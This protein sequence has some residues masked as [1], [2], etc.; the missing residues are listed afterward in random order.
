[1]FAKT[2]LI[3][4]LLLALAAVAQPRPAS[5]QTYPSGD[6]VIRAIWEQG[7]G[8]A[9]EIQDIAQILMD[10]IGPRLYGSPGEAA[11]RD[12]LVKMYGMWGVPTRLHEYG[13]WSGWQ[14]GYSHIDLV[15]PRVRTLDGMML[16]WSPGTNGPVE[17]DVLAMPLFTNGADF[18]AWL[19]RVE[20]KF[21]AYS[22]AEPTCRAPESWEALATPESWERMR[23]LQA[24]V[25]GAWMRSVRAAGGG[26]NVVRALEEAGAVGLLQGNWSAG[27]GANKI[28]SAPT[29]GIPALHLSCEDYGLVHRLASKGQ[30]ARIRLDARSEFLGELPVA[31]VLGEL[32]GTELPNEFVLL[33]A[34]LDS[35]DGASGATDNGSGTV[36]MM[37]A[38]RILKEVYPNPRRTIVVAHWGGEERGLIG[39]GAYAADHPEVVDGLQ[40]A[41]NQDN[42][43]WRIDFIRMQGFLGAG[44]RF[45]RWLSRIPPEI[46]RHIELDIPG[47]PERG[48]SDHMSFIC[49]EAAGFR[50]QSNYPDYRQYTWHTDIDTYDKLVFD[51]LRNNATLVAM[52][53]YLASEDPERMVVEPRELP[54]GQTWPGCGT[55]RRTSGG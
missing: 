53:A 22:H 50:L 39:S 3:T 10:S 31:N 15:A 4:T 44:E 30:G 40:A 1:M 13:T 17:A 24:Q 12:W 32:R 7:M 46:T 29:N 54:A 8:E 2:R 27:W 18:L 38:M 14:R 47:E 48:G 11:A 42:G 52:L 51:D 23:E 33:T 37:E 45:G 28:F 36:M 9:S 21:V 25:S 41:F 19:P 5:S 6:P 20:G 34:H 55:P 16:A 35:W 43:T 49:R 26:G